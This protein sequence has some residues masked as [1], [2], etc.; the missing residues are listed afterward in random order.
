MQEREADALGA[1]IF[2]ATGYDRQR[3]LALFDKLARLETREEGGAADSHDTAGARRRT[4]SAVF[5]ELQK[6]PARRGK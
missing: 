1:A 2:L 4:V 3:A 6:L 5:E